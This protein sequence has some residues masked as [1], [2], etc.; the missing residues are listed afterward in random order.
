MIDGH[1][2][3]LV[4]VVRVGSGEDPNPLQVGWPL[5]SRDDLPS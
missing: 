3:A 1:D 5:S 2:G 4:A